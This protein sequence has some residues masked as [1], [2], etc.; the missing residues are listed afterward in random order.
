MR[1]EHLYRAALWAAVIGMMA[2]IFAFSAQEGPESD[3]LTQATAMPIAELLTSMQEG[4][5]EQTTAYL[6][7]IIGT[8][9]RKVAHLME[10]ALLGLLLTLLCRSHARTAKWLPVAL[11][12]AYAATDELHQAFVPGRLGTPV[13]VLIDAAGVLCGA[14]VTDMIEKFRRK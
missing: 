5:D 6:Y 2:V 12:I 10:Y 7:T 14:C 13:D 1:R 4:A 3:A 8:V 9:V 11:G